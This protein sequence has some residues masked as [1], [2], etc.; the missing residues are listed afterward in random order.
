MDEILARLEND[1]FF[2]LLYVCVMSQP[3]N[4]SSIH[5]Q[6]PFTLVYLLLLAYI[7]CSAQL[8]SHLEQWPF[9]DALYF[10]I[11]SVLTIGFGGFFHN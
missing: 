1:L 5:S 8:V 2:Y 9:L 6:V 3:T 4:F 7:L 10:I 11:M